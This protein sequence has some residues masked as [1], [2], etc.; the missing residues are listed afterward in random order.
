MLH[1]VYTCVEC[2]KEEKVQVRRE[3]EPLYKSR[4]A[5]HREG[6][7]CRQYWP[8]VDDKLPDG[9][10]ICNLGCFYCAECAEG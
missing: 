4:A 10:E 5:F 1:Y 9:W 3:T 6:G 2:F 7:F 8:T